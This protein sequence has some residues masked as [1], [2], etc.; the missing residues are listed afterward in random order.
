MWLDSSAFLCSVLTP[1]PILVLSTHTLVSGFNFALYI[2]YGSDEAFP[3][4]LS[5]WEVSSRRGI[6]VVLVGPEI[7]VH[8][9][10]RIRQASRMITE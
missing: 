10:K 2:N 4:I 6:S 5:L 9:P 3:P 8:L 1:W 7:Q